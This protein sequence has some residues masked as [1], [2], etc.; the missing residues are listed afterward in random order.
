MPYDPACYDLAR[1]FIGKYAPSRLYDEL[2]QHIQDEIEDWLEWQAG[3]VADTD[4]P[5]IDDVRGILK[6]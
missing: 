2:A 6:P 3:T 5:T 4:P 1:R